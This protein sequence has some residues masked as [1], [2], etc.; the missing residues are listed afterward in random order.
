LAGL[1]IWD[2]FLD[3]DFYFFVC[4][5]FAAF[6]A[7]CPEEGEDDVCVFDVDDWPCEVH[8]SE[9]AHAV[10]EGSAA[11]FASDAWV[12]DA[13]P[14]IHESSIYWE[15]FLVVELRGDDFGACHFFDSVW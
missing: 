4:K 10:L 13:E 3:F 9:V 12:N 11:G 1:F 5:E 8:V 14:D 6:S 7:A 2:F 15:S